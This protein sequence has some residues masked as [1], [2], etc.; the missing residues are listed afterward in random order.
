[1]SDADDDIN[2]TDRTLQE[3]DF[4]I[5]SGG[6]K[7]PLKEARASKRVDAPEVLITPQ[8]RLDSTRPQQVASIEETADDPLPPT[9]A[10]QTSARAPM[11]IVIPADFATTKGHPIPRSAS[12]GARRNHEITPGDLLSSELTDQTPLVVAEYTDPAAVSAL[13]RT[14]P[15]STNQPNVVHDERSPPSNAA[16]LEG[17]LEGPGSLA[18]DRTVSL[19]RITPDKT[20]PIAAPVDPT[21]L[22]PRRQSSPDAAKTPQP[23]ST[24]SRGQ[25]ALIGIAVAAIIAIGI[26]LFA[27]IKTAT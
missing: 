24:K 12:S 1:M 11:G 10:R 14:E 23:D 2:E 7:D 18:E 20:A 15:P 6:S 3:R 22:L 16:T 17:E 25:L 9:S 26:T 8:P 4:A 5:A 21:L 13:R 19:L 27:L